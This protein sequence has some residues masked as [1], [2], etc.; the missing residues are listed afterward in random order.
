M[1]MS[2]VA[3]EIFAKMLKLGLWGSIKVEYGGNGMG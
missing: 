1:E 3:K 2:G